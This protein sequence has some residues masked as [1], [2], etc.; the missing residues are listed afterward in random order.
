MS[1]PRFELAT[2]PLDQGTVLL[3]ASAGTGKTYTLVGILLRLLLEARIE[4][5][6]Q[7]LVVTFTVAATEEL[8][9]RLR[10]ALVRARNAVHEPD[11]DPFYAALGQRPGAAPILQ[12]AIEDFDLVS[13]ATI[14]GFCKRLLDEAAFESREPFQVDFTTDPLPRFHRAAAD[15][16]RGLYTPEPTVVASLLC[17]AKL[18]PD[19]LVEAYRLWQRYPDV[20]LT[21]DPA[22]PEPALQEL[23]AA[24]Q[25]AASAFDDEAE[26]RLARFQWLKDGSP[27]DGDGE[28]AARQLRLQLQRD[29]RLCL[30]LLRNLSRTR[31]EETLRKR[32]A[33]STDHTFHAACDDVQRLCDAALEHL[34]V[35]LLRRM[36][37][38]LLA[39]NRADHV[40]SFQDLLVRTHAALHDD[41]RSAPLLQA[42]RQRYRAAL[43]DE[44]Q[45]TDDLQY[46]IFARCF[47]KRPLFLVGDP[48]QSIYGFRGADLR[49][50]LQ[51]RDDAVQQNTLDTNFRSSAALVAAVDR[52]FA[53]ADAFVQTDVV[54]PKVR[55]KAAPGQL[56]LGGDPGPALQWRFLAA[57]DGKQLG[58]DLAEPRIAADTADEI[59]RLLQLGCTVDDRPLRPRHLAVLTRTNRQAV[60]VQDELRRAGVASAIGKAG[61]VFDTEEIDELE[62]FLQA[63]LQPGD[64]ARAR[65]AMATRLWGHDAASLAALESDERALDAELAR[66][67]RWR[68]LWIRRG[69]VVMAE[70]VLADLG[71][72]GR[73]L[74][75]R[76]GERR[77][78]NLQ[79]LFELLHEAEHASRLSP[80]GLLEWLQHERR[81]RDEIDYQLREL[82]L[83]SDDD[84]VQ[85]LTVHGSKGL[86]YEVVFCPFL[87]DGRMPPATAIVPGP[88][89]REL[90]FGLRKGDPR[91]HAAEQE[92][93]AEDVRLCYVALTR[94]KRRC[95]VH[96]GALGSSTN[97]S[98]R[99]ALAWLLSPQRAARQPDAQGQIPAN[100]LEAWIERVKD[101]APKY[102][103][104]LQAL[105][106]DN[107]DTMGFHLVPRQPTPRR[108]EVAPEAALP[109][110]RR[111]ARLVRAR[112]M[113]S[114]SSLVGDHS[115]LDAGRDVADRPTAASDAVRLPAEPA[116]GIFAFARGPAAG[117]CLHTI[118]ER[119]DLA[120]LGESTTERIRQMLA[121][122]G[123]ADP[124]AHAGDIDPAA[125][126]R[127]NLLDLT[128]ALVHANGPSLGALLTG[129]RAPEWSFLLPTHHSDLRHLAQA[130]ASSSSAKAREFAPRLLQLGKPALRGFLNGFVDLVAEHDGRF[131][132]LDWK[133]NHLGNSPA[134]YAPAHLHAAMRDHDYVLQYHLYVL[135][136]HRHLRERLPGYEPERHLG[137]VAYVFLRGVVPGTDNGVVYDRVP[138]PLVLAMDRWAEGQLGGGA[139]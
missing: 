62:R 120:D 42:I 106:A 50:Y 75:W 44:F 124:A 13:V 52:L 97:G 127:Q 100:W 93:L 46:G 130:F 121:E 64:L 78:T 16:L 90:V 41:R 29:A 129:R 70:Q 125:A 60:L 94:A 116:R 63:L 30:G 67:D 71:T 110:T 101:D 135:A 65:A 92:R 11:P 45:D 1:F 19:A 77:L 132:V 3:E 43:I 66:L 79:Q 69:F 32:P 126:V 37:E 48:K 56:Q 49:T 80:E 22:D 82:R 24:V 21:P 31:L 102:G 7:A 25:R 17:I 54:M 55:A 73:F 117:Q 86:E 33:Q 8:K 59:T 123:L 98:H 83:E 2:A 34:R 104:H 99:S 9:T 136:L 5:L 23:A 112:G 89:G 138:T 109:P 118:L 103:P 119:V 18:T 115:P 26:R 12:R 122:D 4:R 57:D 131:W 81:H 61:D 96:W 20:Q 35:Q 108:L 38:R 6:D 39:D 133:S 84:A 139:R 111:P 74:L 128:G 85:I 113:H 51:A 114:F 10:A 68:R 76:T 137:G 40:M 91:W 134:D 95:Y 28:F 53:R 72:V 47:Q 14:H 58:R 105:V 87:W 107:G 88:R 27:L 36:H 15:A